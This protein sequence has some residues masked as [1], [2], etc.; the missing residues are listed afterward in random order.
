MARVY[1]TAEDYQTYSGQAP[2]ADIAA[3]LARATRMLES[4]VLRLCWYEVGSDG[5]P[6]APVV[7]D[8]IRD[9]VCAQVQW[10]GEVGD[11]IGGAGAGWGSVEIGSAKLSRSLVGVSGDDSPAREIAPQVWDALR[12]P[13]LTPDVF[14]LG[15]VST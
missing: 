8:A 15:E 7:A 5:M 6:T 1:A 4:R 14:R 13:D 10:W 12:S 9:A 11:S 2:P 3:L